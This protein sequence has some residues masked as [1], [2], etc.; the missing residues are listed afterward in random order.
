M[1]QRRLQCGIKGGFRR[2]YMWIRGQGTGDNAQ[3]G[4]RGGYRAA[5]RGEYTA[6]VQG[7][8]RERVLGRLQDSILGML[9]RKM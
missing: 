6:R 4:R 9:K 2:V 8:H 3:E 1:I 7:G 5:Y